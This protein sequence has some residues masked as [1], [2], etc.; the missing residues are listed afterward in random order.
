VVKV[1][2][3]I[4]YVLTDPMPYLL[5]LTIAGTPEQRMDVHEYLT[6][7]RNKYKGVKYDKTI[8]RVTSKEVHKRQW[9][10]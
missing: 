1:S 10:D 2:V 6:R 5:L 3:S 9:H 4:D 8:R 7:C